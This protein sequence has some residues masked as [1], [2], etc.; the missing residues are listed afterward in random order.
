MFS[1]FSQFFVSIS[2]S[3]V[4]FPLLLFA[5]G[6]GEVTEAT[7]DFQ[8]VRVTGVA[9]VKNI[10]GKPFQAISVDVIVR[11]KPIEVVMK[12]GDVWSKRVKL[13]TGKSQLTAYTRASRKPSESTLMIE[14]IG[15]NVQKTVQKVSMP[16]AVGRNWEFHLVHHTHLDI[17][18]THVQEDVERL[19]MEHLDMALE[20][21]EK[22]RSYPEASQ[23]RWNPEG[24][25]AVESYLKRATD[26]KREKFI[27]AV[28]SGH[29]GLDALYG[30]ALTALYSDE[31]LFALVGYAV[32]LREKYGLTIDSAMISDVPGL[33][34]GI[35]PTLA[36][37]GVRYISSG[38]NHCH[39]IGRIRRL[40]DR[41]FWWVS[42]DRS[43]KVLYMQLSKSYSWFH[44]GRTGETLTEKRFED[45]IQELKQKN[46][47][48]EMVKT[49]YN[50]GAD[51]GPPQ[52]SLS[53]TVRAW[54]ERYDSPKLII[55]TTSQMFNE[56]ERRYGDDLP[57]LTG[58]I[59]P[60]W[61]DGAASTS[62]DT[63]ACR[64]ATERLVQAQTVW[65]ML[66][67]KNYPADRFYAAWREA[68]LYDEH[69][70]G[71][72]N[73]ITEPD[74][75][76]AKRQADRKGRFARDAYKMADELLADALAARLYGLKPD[77]QIKSVEI[78]NTESRTRTDVVILP[79]NWN[80]AGDRVIDNRGQAVPSQRLH[81][82]RLAFVAKDIPPIGS[83]L[84][85]LSAGK[86]V[87]SGKALAKLTG[88]AAWL[89]NSRVRLCVD[90]ISGAI[91]ELYLQGLKQN[92][93]D[94][95][96]GQLNEY[97]YVDGRDRTK[98]RRIE[99]ATAR[100]LDAGPL[101]ATVEVSSDAPGAKGLVRQI[102]L[103]DGFDRVDLIN[104]IDKKAVRTPEGVFFAFAFNVPDG[105]V[106]MDMPWSVV[107][108][109]ADQMDAACRNY[110]AI[111]RWVDVGSR[112]FGLRWA[113]VNAPLIQLG[114]I[115]TDVRC[116]DK[117]EWMFDDRIEPTQKIFSYVMNNY[118]ETNYKADQEGKIVFRYSIEPYTGMYSPIRSA[119]FGIDRCRPLLVIPASPN[120]TKPIESL[121][122]VDNPNVLISSIKPSRDR[123]ATM[124]RLFA[125]GGEPSTV[126]ITSRDGWKF[127]RSTADQKRGEPV[128]G[129]IRMS[130]FEVLLLRAE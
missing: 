31:E 74:S 39:R 78:F 4:C 7:S 77:E 86:G 120:G 23:F 87:T 73:S 121:V 40:D 81:D 66:D 91:S 26:T 44:R 101:V 8:V 95:K 108:P 99:Q 33:T 38:P 5:S 83:A 25:W 47:P 97:I 18:Y 11:A 89:E 104:T 107:R 37:S 80:L 28:R 72:H 41:P 116:Q 65:T 69:T 70:W 14:P 124:V 105:T 102:R 51:N 30:N 59:T 125:A 130:A 129:P 9:F 12:V 48:Y 96:N 16:A 3:L 42:P 27:A 103:V 94:T 52:P 79:K 1:L 110:M 75:Q 88:G 85:T 45:Y 53:D 56:F 6:G 123:R 61:E 21:I 126:E 113:T 64:V 109:E 115:R 117:N 55:S 17:G 10:D 62:A 68:I 119:R 127:Y 49:Q 60:F 112:D 90:P 84:Y 15:L 46:Y 22:T 106:R 32:G 20:L 128:S 114:H 92:L 82:G 13:A 34:W 71:A 2:I 111:Q 36:S 63:S 58:D 19:Q 29:I 43:Q 122:T 67:R 76:F 93:V 35:V 57:V 118:W 100:V 54:N 98:Q 24:L 50:I